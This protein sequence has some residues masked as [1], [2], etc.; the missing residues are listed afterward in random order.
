MGHDC[1]TL[2]GPCGPPP[3]VTPVH[4]VRPVMAAGSGRPADDYTGNGLHLCGVGVVPIPS[5]VSEDCR[6]PQRIG[7]GATRSRTQ[8]GEGTYVLGVC[9]R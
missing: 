9:Y 1:G 3:A 4:A 8:D 7:P 6:R 5:R 2:L